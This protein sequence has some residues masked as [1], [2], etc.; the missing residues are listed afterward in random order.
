MANLMD[1]VDVV[2]DIVRAEGWKRWVVMLDI[3]TVG[4]DWARNLKFAC[5]F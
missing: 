1:V 2:N 5:K 3:G 4:L